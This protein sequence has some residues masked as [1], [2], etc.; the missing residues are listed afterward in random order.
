MSPAIDDAEA[1]RA[2]A[3]SPPSVGTGTCRAC[4]AD[5]SSKPDP[6]VVVTPGGAFCAHHVRSR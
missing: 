4:G 5:L 3:W 6:W 1:E 2:V